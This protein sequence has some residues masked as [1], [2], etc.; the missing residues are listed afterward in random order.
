MN[1]CKQCYEVQGVED[2]NHVDVK[3]QPRGPNLDNNRLHKNAQESD[4]DKRQG[5]FRE[6]VA[7]APHGLF[8]LE[9]WVVTKN[10]PMEILHPDN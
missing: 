1:Q 10:R 8:E 6:E 2:G 5:D 4:P 7:N 3:R 9:E